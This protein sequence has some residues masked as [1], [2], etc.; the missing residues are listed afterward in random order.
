MGLKAVVNDLSGI[1]ESVQSLYVQDGDVYRLDV[2]GVVDES[3]FNEVKAKV[4]EFRNNNVN[5]MKES[6]TLKNQLSQVNV[7]E[8]NE[9]KGLRQ[10][11][12]DQKLIDA[13]KIDEV[14]A[15]RSER[16]KN[17]FEQQIDAFK[18]KV[19]SLEEH[20]ST[21]DKKL[22]EVTIDTMLT[23]SLNK[24]G[25]L[26]EGAFEDAMARGR[27]TFKLDDGGNPIPLDITGNP[28]ASKDDPTKYMSAEE[29]AYEVRE[30]APHLFE[31]SS[32]SAGEQGRGSGVHVST[33]GDR[34]ISR[35]DKQ[36]FAQNLEKIAA[37]EISVVG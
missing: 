10:Q 28:I 18:Q 23:E 13:G 15:Q 6:E 9:L 11:I 32:G 34:L 4:D 8:Y 19:S 16:M 21:K 37:G 27:R 35:D 22:A 14:V 29:W 7:E 26:R 30:K 24:V 31:P 36:S 3:K 12:E 33:S 2:E 17:Q 1:D 25:S 20:L 5:L